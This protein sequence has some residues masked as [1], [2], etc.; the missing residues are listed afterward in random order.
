VGYPRSSRGLV[1]GVITLVVSSSAACST[2]YMPRSS[3]R[4][5]VVQVGGIPSYVRDGKVYEG[6]VGGGELEEAVHGN[7]EAEQHARD[8]KSGTIS[9][10]VS[11]LVGAAGMFGGAGLLA[12]DSAAADHDRGRQISGA[13]LAGAGLTAYIVGLV[14]IT[15][16][17]PHMW[18]AI[19][20][21]NDGVRPPL[22]PP[23]PRSI[24]APSAPA[25]APAAAP[26]VVPASRAEPSEVP[27][28]PPAPAQ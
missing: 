25:P 23:L 2:S 20:V 21:Y 9:G 26:P 13:A 16:A 14:L 18:D 27:A 17:Q 24:P 15:T 7:P 4:I 1:Y 22:P 11:V 6:G 19:N 28:P 12:A 10:L 5:S 3:G 8:Y